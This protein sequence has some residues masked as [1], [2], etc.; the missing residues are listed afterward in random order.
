VD[1]AA[2]SETPG[3]AIPGACTQQSLFSAWQNADRG[4]YTSL[5]IHPNAR[6]HVSTIVKHAELA[7][8]DISRFRSIAVTDDPASSYVLLWNAPKPLGKMY[9]SDISADTLSPDA[10]LLIINVQDADDVATRRAICDELRPMLAGRH[11][12]TQNGWEGAKL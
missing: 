8:C 5:R 3:R 4:L 10:G 9:A 12:E 1:Q 2:L 11:G 7:N 6:N